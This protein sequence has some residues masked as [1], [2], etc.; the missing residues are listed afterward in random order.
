MRAQHDVDRVADD[1]ARRSLAAELWIERV[2]KCL[3]E[4][5][6]LRQIRHGK[7]EIDLFVRGFFRA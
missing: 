4:V 6:G 3:V 5:L 7:V 1:D 2:A